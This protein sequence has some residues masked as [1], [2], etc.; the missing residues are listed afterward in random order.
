[1]LIWCLANLRISLWCHDCWCKAVR[2]Y[3]QPRAWPG[4]SA[5]QVIEITVHQGQVKIARAYF[6]HN[7]KVRCVPS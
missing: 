7:M 4:A 5:Q 2:Q 3:N 1:M 6:V